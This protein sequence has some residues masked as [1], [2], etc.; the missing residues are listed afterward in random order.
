MTVIDTQTKRIV[1]RINAGTSP[2]GVAI[3]P[4]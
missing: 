1:T 4:R 2:W 3:V